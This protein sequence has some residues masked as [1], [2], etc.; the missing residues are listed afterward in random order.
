MEGQ[1]VHSRSIHLVRFVPYLLPAVLVWLAAC[2]TN[3]ATGRSQWIMLS[4]GQEVSIGEQASPEFIVELG[5]EIPSQGIRH[6]VNALG[7]RIAAVSERPDLPWEFKVVDSQVLNAF[8][9]PGGKV[10]ISRGLLAKLKDEAMLVGV[11]GHEVGHTTAKHVG[12]QMTSQMLLAGAVAATGVAADRNDSDWLRILGVGAHV[13]GGLYL[14][15]FSREH[16]HESDGLAFRYMTK[17]DYD[18]LAMLRVLKVLAKAAEDSP[19]SSIFSTHPAPAQ[20]VD[21]AAAYIRR[22]Y[23]DAGLPGK[24]IV[25]APQFENEVLA[26]LATLPPPKHPAKKKR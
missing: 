2:T 9:L 1:W 16:E 17:L 26:V 23:P 20:R 12:E 19:R 7:M 13:G 5:G 4:P 8:A 24:Y 18:P 21:R 11:L 25:N 6:Y 22:K 3:S 14:L 10:F 15:K